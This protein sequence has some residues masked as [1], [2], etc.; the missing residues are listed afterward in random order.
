M[1]WIAERA[2]QRNAATIEIPFR[3][4][5]DNQTF[6]DFLTQMK[7]DDQQS[8]ASVQ[9]SSV[10]KAFLLL[11]VAGLRDRSL[12]SARNPEAAA[13]IYSSTYSLPDLAG[14]DG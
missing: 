14:V 11:P 3:K 13:A 9:P 10:E 8:S 12:A 6:H 2:E 5:R 1:A 7:L 4:G